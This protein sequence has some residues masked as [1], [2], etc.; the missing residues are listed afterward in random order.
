MLY[1]SCMKADPLAGS[2]QFVARYL[3]HHKA[4]IAFLRDCSEILDAN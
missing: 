2:Y 1:S 4:S 3:F